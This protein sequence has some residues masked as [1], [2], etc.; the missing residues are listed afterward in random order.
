MRLLIVEDHHPTAMA[1][2]AVLA[3]EWPGSVID[4]VSSAETALV[5]LTEHQYDAIVSDVKLPG[6]DG[7]GLLIAGRLLQRRVPFILVSAYGD[8]VLEETG[9]RLGAHAVLHKPV[10]AETLRDIL[11]GALEQSGRS[12]LANPSLLEVPPTVRSQPGEARPSEYRLY[13]DSNPPPR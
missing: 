6:L 12:A 4:V 2:E 1:Y 13:P 7:L 5:A 9:V 8:R 3:Q 11:H 10:R